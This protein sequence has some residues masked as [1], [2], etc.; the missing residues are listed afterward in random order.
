MPSEPSRH[1][2]F[3]QLLPQ[4]GGVAQ[5]Y[6]EA[7]VPAVEDVELVPHLEEPISG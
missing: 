4:L 3:L 7:G 5:L 1:P 6:D 2:E